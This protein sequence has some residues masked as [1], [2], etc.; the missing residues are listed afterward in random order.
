MAKKIP[1]SFMDGPLGSQHTIQWINTM[2]TLSFINWVTRGQKVHNRL[3]KLSLVSVA[4]AMPHTL[5][6]DSLGVNN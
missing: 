5:L 2:A 6:D 1:T 4:C 3:I